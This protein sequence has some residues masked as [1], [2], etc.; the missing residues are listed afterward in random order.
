MISIIFS[1]LL[2]LGLAGQ[3]C[4]PKG[5]VLTWDF[6][7]TSTIEFSLTIDQY[8]WTNYQWVGIGFKYP[9]E[10][11]GKVGA[12]INNIILNE[13]PG[14]SF[15]EH[16]GAPVPDIELPGGEDNILNPSLQDMVYSWSRPVDS[17]DGYDKVYVED[18]EI[19]VLWACGKVLN[20]VQVKHTDS[21]RD[22]T[23]VVLSEDYSSGC[24][25]AF[26]QIN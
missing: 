23:T 22:A 20:G 16:N 12:D 21:D 18:A 24:S 11:E 25:D 9:D 4:L 17:G 14:D 5:W 3:V 2:A 7:S 19:S 10:E 6:P 13:M 1:C 26:L 15:A 8:T